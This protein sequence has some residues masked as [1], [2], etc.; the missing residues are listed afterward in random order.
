MVNFFFPIG[1]A[2]CLVCCVDAF[3]T[4]GLRMS[5]SEQA[6][7]KNNIIARRLLLQ[8]AAVSIFANPLVSAAATGD[9]STVSSI[10]GPVQ[11]L[12]SPGHWVGQFIGINSHTEAWRFDKASPAQVSDALIQVDIPIVFL[13]TQA[14]GKSRKRI[15]LALPPTRPPTHPPKAH[16]HPHELGLPPAQQVTPSLSP[17]TA[18]K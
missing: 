13:A 10:Q 17:P 11:D 16:R 18:P 7:G 3:A 8:S 1:L 9:L 15:S 4:V 14:L 2:L 12:L 5:S 6:P